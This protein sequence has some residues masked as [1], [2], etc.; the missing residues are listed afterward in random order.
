METTIVR[1]EE[2]G[3]PGHGN[4]VTISLDGAPRQIQRGNYV[5]AELKRLLQIDPCRDL[6]EVVCGELRPLED[7]DKTHINGCESFVSH[8][9]CGASS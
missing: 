4:E 8:V 1:H 7:S 3:H 6:D 5:V 2:H 9:R